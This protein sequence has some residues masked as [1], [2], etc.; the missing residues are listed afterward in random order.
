M[1]ELTTAGIALGVTQL[2]EV[3]I[4]TVAFTPGSLLFLYTDGVIETFNEKGELFGKSRLLDFL[5]THRTLE[6]QQL[7]DRLVAEVSQ[8]AKQTLQH[9]DL[10]ILC[11]KNS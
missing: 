10:S 4:K 5:K 9:D 1:E 3:E 2:K 8:F 11:L 7:I 6:P